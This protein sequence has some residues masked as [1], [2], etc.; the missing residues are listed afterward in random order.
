MQ[1]SAVLSTPQGPFIQDKEEA[2][3][4]GRPYLQKAFALL[5]RALRWLAPQSRRDRSRATTSVP[6]SPCCRLWGGF[7]GALGGL[8]GGFGGALGGLWGGGDLAALEG[9]ASSR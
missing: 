3:P 9:I 4:R 8:W 7:G 2:Y 5:A 6:G 1:R